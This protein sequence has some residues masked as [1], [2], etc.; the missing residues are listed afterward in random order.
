MGEMEK[1]NEAGEW[2]MEEGRK[3]LT[4]RIATFSLSPLLLSLCLCVSVAILF[5]KTL[6]ATC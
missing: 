2:T 3:I 5:S 6:T 4:I 1:K